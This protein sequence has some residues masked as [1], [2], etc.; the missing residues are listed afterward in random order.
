MKQWILVAIAVV[1]AGALVALIFFLRS[2]SSAG[3]SAAGDTPAATAVEPDLE[4][5]SGARSRPSLPE[6]GDTVEQSDRADRPYREYV[7]SDGMVVRD[8]RASGTAD[9][10]FVPQV[11]KPVGARKL[12]P[13]VIIAVRNAMRPIV[14]KCAEKLGSEGLGDKPRLHGQITISI[15]E[16][17]ISIDGAAL[18]VADVAEADAQALMD[19]VRDP[20]QQLMLSAAGHDDV[21][22]YMISLPFRLRRP[23]APASAGASE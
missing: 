6:S 10:D 3:A 4:T 23:D 9:P 7:R 15:L 20:M 22:E 14:H 13:E 18:N 2:D 17:Q 8:H 5:G 19:C 21:T 1:T 12:K 11:Q 16:G